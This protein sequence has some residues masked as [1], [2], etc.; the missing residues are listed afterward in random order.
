MRHAKR[1]KLTVEDF[2]RALRWSNV[3]VK[4]P[5]RGM[6][7]GSSMFGISRTIARSKKRTVNVNGYYVYIVY[8]KVFDAPNPHIFASGNTLEYNC[9]WPFCP[10]TV[11]VLPRPSVATAP[12]TSF[13]SVR[14]RKGNCSSWRTET[15]TWW[16]WRWPPT[17]PKAVP[18]RWSEVSRYGSRYGSSTWKSS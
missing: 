12:R 17:F 9:R 5:N 16:S 15:S 18:K 10:F 11:F 14:S 8:C 13:P 6:L 1:R 3:E 7:S 4:G 2:N